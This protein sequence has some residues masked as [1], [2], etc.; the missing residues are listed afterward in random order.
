MLHDRPE[1]ARHG[2]S[3]QPLEEVWPHA[4]SPVRTWADASIGIPL[5]RRHLRSAKTH[6]LPGERGVIIRVG[7]N[8]CGERKRVTPASSFDQ[9]WSGAVFELYN[10]ANGAQILT[11]SITS[12]AEGQ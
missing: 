11:G 8:V 4:S 12:Y 3:G 1:M 7:K 6:V 2:E 10:I 5:S 9:L